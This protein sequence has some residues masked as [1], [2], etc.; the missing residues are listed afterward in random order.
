MKVAT[1]ILSL[2]VL[3]AFTTLYI[4]CDSGGGDD[5]SEQSV[6]FKKLAGAWTVSTVT[7]GTGTTRD[8]F[9]GVTLNLGGTFSENGS[10]PYSVGG[11]LPT[12]SPW[13]KSGNWK[14]GTDPSEDIIRDSGDEEITCK[15]VV[16]SDATSL[17]IT[18]QV[19]DGSDG[20]PGGRVNSVTG[21]WTFNFTK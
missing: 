17:Q 15:Y 13:P 6:Q 16:S 8:D 18:F 19:P 1:R 14:F 10:Y 3:V 12:P 2:L 5:E 9:D 20:W 7:D 4:G 11:I 21:E